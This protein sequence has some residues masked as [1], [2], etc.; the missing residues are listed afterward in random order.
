MG[1]GKGPK[2]ALFLLFY[3][4]VPL[5]VPLASFSLNLG[6]PG[7]HFATFLGALGFILA[8]LGPTKMMAR[9]CKIQ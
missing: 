8:P 5:W 9:E 1:G 7:H 3:S 6:L 4:L 2:N